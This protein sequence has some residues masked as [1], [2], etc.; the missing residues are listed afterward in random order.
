MS[1]KNH[2]CFSSVK[3]A[4]LIGL[5]TIG[6]GPTAVVDGYR[7]L[8]LFP[9]PIVSHF[10]FFQPILRGLAEAGHNVTVI[11]YFPQPN[12]PANY[13]DIQLNNQPVMTNGIDLD[14]SLFL[15]Y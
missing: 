9:V 10:H 7:I 2:R 4:I 5:L 1:S 14:V 12:P 6:A 3:A 15:F 11:S 8:G 13:K